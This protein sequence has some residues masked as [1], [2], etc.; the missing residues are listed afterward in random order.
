[1]GTG[2]ILTLIG[3]IVTVIGTA[4][5]GAGTWIL[6]NPKVFKNKFKK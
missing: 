6:K 4:L 5:N 2:A 1:M 3:T